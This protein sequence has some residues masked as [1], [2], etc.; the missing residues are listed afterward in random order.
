MASKGSMA[1]WVAFAGILM[2]VVGMI[3]FLQGL[4]AIIRGAY[5]GISPN[6][7]IVFDLR[8][9]GWITLIW[10]CLLILAGM[11]L[12]GG[13]SWA[14]WFTIVLASLTFIEQLG[15]GG[16]SYPIWSLIVLALNIIVLYA[17]IARWDES[18]DAMA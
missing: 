6:Q 13:K 1:G 12:L 2:V 16:S 18:K 4:V 7:I 3:D 10:G 14:R 5:Y 9:W 8:S 15:F 11:G 17:L